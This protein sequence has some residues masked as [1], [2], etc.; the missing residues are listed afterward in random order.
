MSNLKNEGTTADYLMNVF[1]T[2]TFPNHHS[3]ATGVYPETHGVVGNNFYDPKLKR[4]IGIGYEM[5]HYTD[6]IVPIWTLNE[7]AGEGR[8]SGIMMWPGGVY[9]YTGINA[10]YIH[11]WDPTMSWFQ[12]IDTA[13]S[14]ILDKTRP[15]NLV[16]LYFEEPDTHGHVYGPESPVV[17]NLLQQLDNITQYLHDKLRDNGLS[18]RAN[19]IHL[20][21]H[22]MSTVR[23]PQFID[24]TQ[25]LKPNTYQIADTSPCLHFIPNAGFE[26]DVYTRLKKVAETNKNFKIYK[27]ADLLDRWHYKNNP[28]IPPILAVAEPGYGFQDLTDNVQYY[29]KTYHLK[30]TAKSE[31]GVHGYDN[32]VPD[33]HPFFIAKGPAIKSSHKVPPFSTLDLYNLFS[34]ILDLK[35]GKTN[36]TFANVRDILQPVKHQIVTPILVA[37]GGFIISVSLIGCIASFTILFKRNKIRTEYPTTFENILQNEHNLIEAQH[38][39][40]PEEI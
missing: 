27:K 23:P 18:S 15:A 33:M 21:D 39:L 9:E 35:P 34:T 1:P 40:E 24:L 3:I 29:V 14:W 28:R 32:E 10:T 8:H 30:V 26:D 16:M 2:K 19:V 11:Q 12:R 25:H 4:L 22:G 36:G 38:L 7:K 31:F 13:M 17:Y 6:E 20:S 37:V 5:Y